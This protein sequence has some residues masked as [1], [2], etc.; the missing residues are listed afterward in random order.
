MSTLVTE[1]R[2]TP[3]SFHPP[4]WQPQEFTEPRNQKLACARSGP[5]PAASSQE[6]ACLGK[7]TPEL[8]FPSFP[9]LSLDRHCV[10]EPHL[11]EIPAL[12]PHQDP[13]LLCGYHTRQSEYLRFLLEKLSSFCSSSKLSTL[14]LSLG[15]DS[16][17]QSPQVWCH[18]HQLDIPTFPEECHRSSCPHVTTE[19]DEQKEAGL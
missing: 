15:S 2:P 12:L 18:Q 9:I 1:P 10:L 4:R 8:L 5:T 13:I 19:E 16:G 7:A 17:C 3:T 6:P 14:S 11:D